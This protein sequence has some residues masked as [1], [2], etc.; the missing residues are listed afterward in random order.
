M[1]I[2]I[3]LLWV[4]V[5]ICGGTESYIRNLLDGF[6]EFAPEQD[7]VLF[8]AR[9]NVESFRHYTK[10]SCFILYVCQVD[11]SNQMK[12]ILW[13]NRN[14]DKIAQEE[15]VDVM[16]IP[17][18]SK[19]STHGSGIPYVSVIHDLQAIHYPQYFSFI[20]RLFLKYAWRKTC[21]TSEQVVTISDYGR[22]D[23]ITHYPYVKNKI[24][25]VY[26][27]IISRPSQIPLSY[28]EKKYHITR[29]EYFYCVSSMLPHKN[30]PTLLCA[31][32]KRKEQGKTQEKLVLSGVGADS[33]KM[34]ELLEGYGIQDMVI[35]TGFISDG[36]RDCLY[37]NCRLFL[38]PS[39]F[40]GFGM[41]PIEAMRKGKNV[42]MTEKSC[43][44][45]VTDG[46]AIYVQDPFDADEWNEKIDEGEKRPPAVQRFEQYELRNVVRQ[47]IKILTEKHR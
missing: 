23:I 29:E 26:N 14:L 43:L 17:V 34:Q 47:Y 8:V 22:E 9:D 6:A 5:G 42:V 38:F 33:Q 46:K 1:R 28:I 25:T 45:E 2:G 41:P 10:Y 12:R 24:H 16:F 44:R 27:P 3:D 15:K 18:Y 35:F 40:E 20:K 32:Q 30:L 7:Y 31:M 37:E 36:E 19:P 4:R 11:C 39:V 13:E 21:R